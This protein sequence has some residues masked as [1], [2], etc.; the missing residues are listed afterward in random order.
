[1]T[2][3]LNF[4]KK[5]L[6]DLRVK[7]QKLVL[8]NSSD[9][10]MAPPHFEANPHLKLLTESLCLLYSNANLRLEEKFTEYISILFDISYPHYNNP[11]PSITIVNMELKATQATPVRLQKGSLLEMSHENEK[12]T[13]RTCGSAC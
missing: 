9:S 2:N 12:C 8:N 10:K 3:I 5:E 6:Q 4:Y 11:I 13:F 7:I 1:M